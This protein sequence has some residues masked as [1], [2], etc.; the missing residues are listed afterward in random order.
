MPEFIVKCDRIIC[1]HL[2]FGF[3]RALLRE[4]HVVPLA[5]LTLLDF[6]AAFAVMSLLTTPETSIQPYM[7]FVHDQT[8]DIFETT[9]W[10]WYE[11]VNFHLVHS[12]LNV[13]W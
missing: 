11:H 13:C 5:I 4:G 7:L 2:L 10:I 8:A 6:L 9:Q 12:N 1:P 3:D